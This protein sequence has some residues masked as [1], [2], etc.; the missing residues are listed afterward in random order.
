M[1]EIVLGL[2]W[3]IVISICFYHFLKYLDK[4]FE[5]EKYDR[6]EQINIYK[7]QLTTLKLKHDEIEQILEVQQKY[8]EQLKNDMNSIKLAKGY[9]RL[10]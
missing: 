4:R 3:P 2:S 7:D 9:D 10:V 1:N 6:R 5:Y 8:V